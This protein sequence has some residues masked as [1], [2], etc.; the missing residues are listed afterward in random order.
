MVTG[1]LQNRGEESHDPLVTQTEE[2]TVCLVIFGP[3]S[4]SY[5]GKEHDL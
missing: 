3:R 1:G 2:M 4:F 5:D